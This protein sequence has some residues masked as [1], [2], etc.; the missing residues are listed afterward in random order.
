[1]R[2]KTKLIISFLVVL[3]VP[4]LLTSVA[5]LGFGQYQLHSIEKN[6]GV[7]DA[8]YENFANATSILSKVTK[9]IYVTLRDQAMSDPTVFEDAA[10]LDAI[11]GQLRERHSYLLVQKG[12]SYVYQ[13]IESDVTSLMERIPGHGEYTMAADVGVF[14]GGDIQSLIKK[15][16][17]LFQNMNQIKRLI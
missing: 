7:E 15:V 13:G 17:V 8:E 4:L 12:D 1:M 10:Y 2:L 11:N 6:F 16:D 14:V 3:L 5:L 9:G